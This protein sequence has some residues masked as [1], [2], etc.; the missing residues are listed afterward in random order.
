MYVQEH[1]GIF[2]ILFLFFVFFLPQI[3]KY[4]I[5]AKTFIKVKFVYPN[6]T[7]SVELMSSFFDEEN[8]PTEF[9]GKALLQYNHEEFSKQMNQ[10]DVKTAN[11]W[12]LVHNNNNQQHASNG[13]SGA[14]I[15]PE[16]IQT[17]P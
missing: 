17:N 14:E 13:F 10:D 8:L 9:G 11:F 7:E 1:D 2:F 6:N 3:V 15:A 12:G 16:P 4:F 5:D